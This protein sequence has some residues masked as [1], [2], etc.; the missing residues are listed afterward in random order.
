MKGQLPTTFIAF[1]LSIIT[2][3]II[4]LILPNILAA[5][6]FITGHPPIL[7]DVVVKPEQIPLTAD[8]TLYS[9]LSSTDEQTG[10]SVQELLA[11]G[12]MYRNTSFVLKDEGKSFNVDLKTIVDSKM[13][14]ILKDFDYNLVVVNRFGIGNENLGVTLTSSQGTTKQIKTVKSRSSS[15]ITLPDLSTVNVVLYMG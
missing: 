4:F 8:H 15:T 6:E 12:A 2:A 1:I 13:K 11:Y 14:F 9:L 5:W 10:K 7:I 3:L